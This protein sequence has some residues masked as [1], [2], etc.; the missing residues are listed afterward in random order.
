[1]NKEKVDKEKKL[2][3]INPAELGFDFDGVIADT[4]GSFLR[5]ACDRYGLC[6]LRLEDI[7]NFEVEECLDIDPAIIQSIFMEILLDSIGTG[8]LPMPGAVEVMSELSELAE[9]TIVTAR[10]Q[11]DPVHAWLKTVFPQSTCTRIRVIAMGDHDDKPQ[12]IQRLGLT[13]FIDDRAETC[14]Q[15]ESA[16]ICSIVFNH[17][18]N[19][20]RHKLPIVNSWQEIRALCF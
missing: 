1:M 3:K 4:G 17:P 14:A 18:W 7:T 19:K 8:L 11:P 9:L 16:G 13:H 6:D 5:L 15:L 20:N 12:H 2:E 10:P